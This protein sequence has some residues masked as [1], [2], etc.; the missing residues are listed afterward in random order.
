VAEEALRFKQ[1]G[2]IIRN[3]TD[4]GGKHGYGVDPSDVFVFF[5]S[6]QVKTPPAALATSQ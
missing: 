4:D 5:D 3:V 1:D 6:N 2:A